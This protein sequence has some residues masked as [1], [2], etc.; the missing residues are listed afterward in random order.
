MRVN[1]FNEQAAFLIED[2]A[3]LIKQVLV[4]HSAA[5]LE[6]MRDQIVMR[7]TRIKELRELLRV[8]YLRNHRIESPWQC[9]E[10]GCP[11][12]G[13]PIPKDGCKCY[14]KLATEHHSAVK[15]EIGL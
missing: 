3:D 8:E 7:N 12:L 4:K 15:R 14:H 5:V 10:D 6:E 9:V 1:N 11:Y 2:A 13:K